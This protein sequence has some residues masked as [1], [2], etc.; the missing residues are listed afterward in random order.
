MFNSLKRKPK[1]VDPATIEDPNIQELFQTLR[2][3]THGVTLD[4]EFSDKALKISEVISEMGPY[5]HS[6]K[7]LIEELVGESIPFVL[8]EW[9][10][11]CV[12]VPVKNPNSHDYRLGQPSSR[13]GISTNQRCF[14]QGGLGPLFYDHE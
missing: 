2:K 14:E 4:T 11:G 13:L 6:A 7:L 3:L 9:G 8:D 12:V 1:V 10:V 5:A